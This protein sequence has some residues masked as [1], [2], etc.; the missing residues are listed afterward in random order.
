MHKLI[1]KFVED[2]ENFVYDVKTKLEE[3][4]GRNTKIEV[5]GEATIS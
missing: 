1:Y 4:K 2:I 3:E 5:L